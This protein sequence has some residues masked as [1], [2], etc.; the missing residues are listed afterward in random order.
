MGTPEPRRTLITRSYRK[1]LVWISGS[2]IP[3]DS[4]GLNNRCGSREIVFV[5]SGGFFPARFYE[6]KKSENI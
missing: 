3:S 1:K 4:L 5:F 2:H 6:Q